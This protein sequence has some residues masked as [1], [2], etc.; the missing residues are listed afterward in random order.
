MERPL[1][2]A[3]FHDTYRMA[4]FV[5]GVLQ[6]PFGEYLHF[7]SDFFVDDGWTETF[8]APY[9]EVTSLHH[10]VDYAVRRVYYAENVEGIDLESRKRAW[11]NY[12][13]FAEASGSMRPHMLPVEEAFEAYEIEE[14]S[15]VGLLREQGRPFGEATED[16]LSDHYRELTLG[17]PFDDLVRRVTD[18]VFHVLFS[19]RAT[20][21]LFGLLVAR[22]VVSEA[23]PQDLGAE[24]ARHF[25]A[26][27][28]L[29]RVRPPRWV[30]R[31]VFFRD[32]GRCV[33]C[34]RDLFGLVTFGTENTENY[35]HVVPLAKG[36]QNDLT[37]VQL[38]CAGC[39]LEKGD[40]T[41]TTSS[42]YDSWAPTATPTSLEL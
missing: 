15:F 12:G 40:R 14:D 32:R 38:L 7:V 5:R 30:Q 21:V 28:R 10:F 33:L 34:R 24:G 27:G 23:D 35:D 26:P 13:R 39:N 9:P 41:V 36:G 19:D 4:G 25:E 18:E 20:L 42:T 31:A 16:D 11:S 37:N 3:R 22:R 8:A 2:D 29:R 17:Q 1:I 6:S